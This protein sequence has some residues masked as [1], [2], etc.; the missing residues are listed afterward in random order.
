[1]E[2]LAFGVKDLGSKQPYYYR[3]VL[4]VG[5]IRNLYRSFH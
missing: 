4:G 5:I 3:W 1:M 2:G